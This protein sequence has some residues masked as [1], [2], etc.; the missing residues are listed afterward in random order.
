[1][2]VAKQNTIKHGITPMALDSLA[3][4]LHAPLLKN[5]DTNLRVL[6][7][8][9]KEEQRFVDFLENDFGYSIVKNTFTRDPL[10]VSAFDSMQK[11]KKWFM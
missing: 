6:L 8:S 11:I 3:T 9:L 7:N 1:M 2:S 4:R 5:F 10:N